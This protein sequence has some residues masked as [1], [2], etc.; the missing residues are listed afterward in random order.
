MFNRSNRIIGNNR[1]FLVLKHKRYGNRIPFG[2]PNYGITLS[3]TLVNGHSLIWAFYSRVISHLMHSLDYGFEPKNA[4]LTLELRYAAAVKIHLQ[5]PDSTYFWNNTD[6]VNIGRLKYIEIYAQDGLTK[7]KY[8][9]RLNI[10]QQNPHQLVWT[11]LTDNYLPFPID[12]QKTVAFNN[13]FYT[14]YK[15]GQNIKGVVSSDGT[16]NTPLEV[17]G[18]PPTIQFSSI[19]STPTAIYALDNSYSVYKTIDGVL[20]TKLPEIYQ[21]KSIYGIL[22]SVATDSILTAIN[23]EETLKFAKTS[24]FTSFHVMNAIPTDFPITQFSTTN[25]KDTTIFWG[26]RMFLV[27]GKNADDSP[28]SKIWIIQE[29]DDAILHPATRHLCHPR[30]HL[31]PL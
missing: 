1:I 19:V 4:Y 14:Y 23:D 17:N 18:L 3:A 2:C 22:P 24:D 7:K 25:I 6:S 21:V 9:F 27:G 5:N 10:H 12:A 28:N 15:S 16:T 31:I 30:K 8:E 20:W 13:Q 26:K 11:Q 29:K